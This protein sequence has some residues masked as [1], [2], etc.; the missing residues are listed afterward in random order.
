LTQGLPGVCLIFKAQKVIFS[1]ST[2]QS[3]E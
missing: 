3:L 2:Y 1:H